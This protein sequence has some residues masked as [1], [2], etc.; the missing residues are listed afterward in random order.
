[1]YAYVFLYFIHHT[2]KRTMRMHHKKPLAHQTPPNEGLES[3][4]G[5]LININ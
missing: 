5:E 1:M 4:P 2:D 3:G